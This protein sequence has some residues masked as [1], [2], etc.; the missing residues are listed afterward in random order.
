M[1]FQCKCQCNRQKCKWWYSR[2]FFF[3]ISINLGYSIVLAYRASDAISFCFLLPS[4]APFHS[5][6]LLFGPLFLFLYRSS[7]L[8]LFS[9][10]YPYCVHSLRFS[11]YLAISHTH[12]R[13]LWFVISCLDMSVVCCVYH[14]PACVKVCLLLFVTLAS[15]SRCHWHYCDFCVAQIHSIPQS[16]SS[17]LFFISCYY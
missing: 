6:N 9:S 7:A 3:L 4:F 1:D 10:S 12:T 5:P 15:K 8:F 14:L 13:A 2:Q 17:Y 16:H 11:H